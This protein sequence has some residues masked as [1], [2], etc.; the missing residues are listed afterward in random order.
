MQVVQP[1]QFFL[2]LSEDNFTQKYHGFDIAMRRVVN[3]QS[4]NDLLFTTTLTPLSNQGLCCKKPQKINIS[5]ADRTAA[6]LNHLIENKKDLIQGQ[7]AKRQIKLATITGNLTIFKGRWMDEA[8]AAESG[9]IKANFED[10]V[11]KLD[12]LQNAIVVD[13]N[14]AVIKKR[15]ARTL[16]VAIV[17]LAFVA[18]KFPS[19]RP[20]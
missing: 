8:P 13:N 3:Q 14:R 9:R 16:T 7:I 12:G 5:D 20:F 15:I 2:A 17:A 18:Y 11:V 1:T 19:L 4:R 10:A 6:N